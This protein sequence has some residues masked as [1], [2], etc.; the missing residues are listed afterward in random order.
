[1]FTTHEYVGG[2]DASTEIERQISLTINNLA[3]R[4]PVA[5]MSNHIVWLPG[6]AG[7]LKF[8][9]HDG[10]YWMIQFEKDTLRTESISFWPSEEGSQPLE[11][12][13]W[14]RE[15]KGEKKIKNY[16]WMRIADRPKVL[17]I[18]HAALDV[19][20]AGLASRF[21]EMEQHISDLVEIRKYARTLG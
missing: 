3:H 21:P 18:C 19:L 4:F 12:L 7:Q 6:G 13:T 9:R 8:S 17:M 11:W 16:L 1:M 14:T 20:L 15:T 2:L 5:V 10:S